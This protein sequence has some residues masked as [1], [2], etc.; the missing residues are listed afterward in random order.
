MSDDDDE[1][2]NCAV[3]NNNDD[4]SVRVRDYCVAFTREVTVL[5][6]VRACVY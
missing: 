3:N 6:S 2:N 5:T 4:N 1:N